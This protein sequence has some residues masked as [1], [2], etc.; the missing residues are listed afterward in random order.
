MKTSCS[1][2]TSENNCFGRGTPTGP[3]KG[4]SKGQVTP[5]RNIRYNKDMFSLLLQ[6]SNEVKKILRHLNLRHSEKIAKKE[7]VFRLQR[8]ML[9][10]SV[11]AEV[12]GLRQRIEE[13]VQDFIS[14]AE[15]S[16][17]KRL[18]KKWRE[19]PTL[20]LSPA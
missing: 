20:R 12:E 16:Y 11:S 6:Q 9:W 8:P 4:G 13:E 5:K 2:D 10:R 14:L 3:Y 17:R 18:H 7:F 15:E 19:S 1:Y